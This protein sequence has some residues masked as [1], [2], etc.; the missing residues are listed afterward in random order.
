MKMIQKGAKKNTFFE[1]TFFKYPITITNF[2]PSKITKL[3]F[4]D[5]NKQSI[6]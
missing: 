6:N 4:A 3:L 2:T 1:R 5:G